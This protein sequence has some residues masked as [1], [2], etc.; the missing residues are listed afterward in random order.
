MKVTIKYNRTD[1]F[2]N[3]E[4]TEDS[5]ICGCNDT[6]LKALQKALKKVLDGTESA[7]QVS[8]YD[9]DDLVI[10]QEYSDRDSDIL[11]VRQY[12]SY[13]AYD[14]RKLSRQAVQKMLRKISQVE[15]AA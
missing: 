4:Y 7:M 3:K 10:W 6:A 5:T 1:F 14:D 12:E 2:G 9:G 8:E 13:N 11:T 15:K